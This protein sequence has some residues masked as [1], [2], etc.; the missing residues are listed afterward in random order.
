MNME[1]CER[2][3][4]GDV[5]RIV[6]FSGALFPLPR[7]LAEREG[8]EVGRVAAPEATAPGVYPCQV[9]GKPC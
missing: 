2:P 7:G 1:A 8:G 4:H 5:W 9:W 3:T 6:L